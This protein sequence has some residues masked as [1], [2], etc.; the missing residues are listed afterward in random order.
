[1]YDHSHPLLSDNIYFLFQIIFFNLC[2]CIIIIIIIIINH[3][4]HL[5]LLGLMGIN[6]NFLGLYDHINTAGTAAIG[7]G[8]G[9]LTSLFYMDFGN[10]YL[11]SYP[12]SIGF[13]AI[14]T[15]FS[16]M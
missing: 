12:N 5:T 11:F 1:M 14:L 6:D 13:D 7:A 2:L 9:H 16:H 3:V 4:G 8:M 15:G 10:N